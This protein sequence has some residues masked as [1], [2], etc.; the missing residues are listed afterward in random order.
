VETMEGFSLLRAMS[1]GRHMD[2][3]EQKEMVR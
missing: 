1:L 2:S 3:K